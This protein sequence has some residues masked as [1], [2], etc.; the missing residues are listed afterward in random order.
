VARGF[1]ST[2]NTQLNSA[3]YPS[4]PTSTQLSIPPDPALLS[5]LPLQTHL[6][7]ALYPSRPTSTQLSIP[8]DHLNSALYPSRPTSTQLSI[9]PGP[10][11]TQ[12]ST[13]PGYTTHYPPQLSPLSLPGTLSYDAVHVG[14]VEVFNQR[15]HEAHLTSRVLQQCLGGRV[16][17]AQTARRHH[18]RQVVHVHPA[19]R[20]V[21]W[22][23]EY[24]TSTT[25]SSTQPPIHPEYT[26]HY[27]CQVVHVHLALQMPYNTI[28]EMRQ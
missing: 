4:G 6:N 14:G 20:H 16:S 13:P 7:S 10:S 22:C 24:L 5:P 9:P 27:R 8:P 17:T 18:G 11:S 12:P 26:T 15:S 28:D 21:V 19:L 2:F 25:P 23:R 1:Q 3:L